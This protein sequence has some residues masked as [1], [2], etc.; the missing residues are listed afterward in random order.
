MNATQ[1]IGR[2]LAPKV[3]NVDPRHPNALD[4]ILRIRI[5]TDTNES[6]VSP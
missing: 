6:R 2:T 1:R 3:S 5:S 4:A